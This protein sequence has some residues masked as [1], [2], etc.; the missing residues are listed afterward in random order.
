VAVSFIVWL[1]D[2]A[3]C[4]SADKPANEQNVKSGFENAKD[5]LGVRQSV[6]VCE[7]PVKL[8]LI[9]ENSEEGGLH[10]RTASEGTKKPDVRRLDCR[11]PPSAGDD[12]TGKDPHKGLDIS[13]V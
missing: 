9:K 10:C 5:R 13:N 12:R 11:K 7:P 4:E 2:M 3:F 6:K 1:G 8:H